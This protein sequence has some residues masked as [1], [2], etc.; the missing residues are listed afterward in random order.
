MENK[1]RGSEK[2]MFVRNFMFMLCLVFA[3]LLTYIVGGLLLS[4]DS[5]SGV[6]Q[7][8]VQEA[9]AYFSGCQILQ[10]NCMDSS[11]NLYDLCGG[12]SLNMCRIYDCTDTYGVFAQDVNGETKAKNE[13][14][15]DN[16]S[17]RAKKQACGASMQVLSQ[18]CADGKMEAKVKLTPKG[19]C[20]IGGFNVVYEGVG[21]QPNSFA[22]LGD[23]TY[24]IT[25]DKCGQISQIIPQT[26]DGIALF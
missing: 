10:E 22:S 25:V 1:N 5:F 11:C 8:A 4:K 16:K 13:Q 18:K 12:G 24:S 14:K 6:Q 21:P 23:N 9:D 17:V 2:V 20:K 19:E 26:E 3:I 15:N 7:D